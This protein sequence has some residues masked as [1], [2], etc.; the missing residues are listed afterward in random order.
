VVYPIVVDKLLPEVGFGWTTRIIGFLA[1]GT[2]AISIA[3]LRQR[4][5]APKRRILFDPKAFSEPPFFFFTISL[6]LGFM[7]LYILSFFIQSFAVEKG[8]GT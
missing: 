8:V 1:L 6:F 2:C 4:I 3:I 5:K 7:G